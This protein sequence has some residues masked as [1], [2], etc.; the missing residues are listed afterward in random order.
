MEKEMGEAKK[1]RKEE[2]VGDSSYSVRLT[3]L[4]KTGTARGVINPGEMIKLAYL[5]LDL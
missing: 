3:K 2:V 4:Y 1:E 5:A